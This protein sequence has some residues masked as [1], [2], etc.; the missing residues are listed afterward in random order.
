MYVGPVDQ[1]RRKGPVGT[2]QL[3]PVAKL[4]LQGLEEAH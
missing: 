1:E 2:S 4:E 3:S